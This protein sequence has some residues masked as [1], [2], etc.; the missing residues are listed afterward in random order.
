MF[1]QHG[2]DKYLETLFA[3][4]STGFCVDV[5]ATDGIS[6]S[7]TYLFEV[8]KGWECICMEPIPAYFDQC[9]RNRKTAICCAVGAQAEEDKEFTVFT[10]NGDNFSAISGLEPDER[11]VESHKHLITNKQTIRV[12]VRTLTSILDEHGAPTTIDFISID[13]ENTELDVL[14]GLDLNKYKVQYF[15]IENNFNEPMIEEYLAGFGFKKI[16]RLAVNDFYKNEAM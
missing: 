8:I 16:H 2:E 7:N 11:L 3:S 6:G 13:T 12:P 5:G 10:L 9:K 15:C 1:S 14:K 4:K